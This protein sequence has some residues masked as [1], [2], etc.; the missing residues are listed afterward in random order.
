VL[1]FCGLSEHIKEEFLGECAIV[2]FA[3]KQIGYSP[4][5]SRSPALCLIGWDQQKDT[6]ILAV[7]GEAKRYCVARP[8]DDLLS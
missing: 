4:R 2:G 6:T 7:V 5:P 3:I 8:I 1:S